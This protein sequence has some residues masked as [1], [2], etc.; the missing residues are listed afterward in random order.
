MIYVEWSPERS[1]AH[2]GRDVQLK[3][4]TDAVPVRPAEP[5]PRL[6][7]D[8]PRPGEEA[9][10][11]LGFAALSHALDTGPAQAGRHPLVPVLVPYLEHNTIK[12]SLS[13]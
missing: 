11:G 10:Q 12:L 5:A 9:H 1:P 4:D 8:V 2:V 7:R 13:Q 6:L 3:L